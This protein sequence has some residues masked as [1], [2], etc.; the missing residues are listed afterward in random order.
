MVGRAGLGASTDVAP[1]RLRMSRTMLLPLV[2]F[3][4]CL[5]PV[6][7]FSPWG[8]LLLLLPVLLAVW[9]LRVGVTVDDDGIGVQSL[10]GRR[11]IGWAELAGIRVGRRGDLW[12]V[13]TR[14]TELRLPVLRA[15]DL[16]RLASLSGGRIDV[17]A[18][19]A[20]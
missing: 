9:V 4:L 6:V 16:P 8:L 19:P 14:G 2:L 17:P 13:T 7:L 1:V 3:A 15:R 12:L 11:R 5:L 18:P 20:G 10:L